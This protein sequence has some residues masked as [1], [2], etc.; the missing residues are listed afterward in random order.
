M[1]PPLA[2]GKVTYDDGTPSTVE[3]QAKDVSA[4]LAWA[5]DPKATERKQFGLAAMIYLTLFSIL[6]WFSYKRVWRNVAH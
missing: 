5:A 2:P 4:F 3:Q 1:T 6:L